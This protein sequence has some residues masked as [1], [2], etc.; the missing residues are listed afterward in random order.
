M[1]TPNMP[2]M[3]QLMKQA[4]ELQSSMQNLQKELANKI[5]TGKAGGGMVE[6]DI[7]G[8]H[9][10]KAVRISSSLVSDAE[11]RQ[12]LEDL[13]VAA[14]NDATTKVEKMSKNEISSLAT[15]LGSLPTDAGDN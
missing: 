3:K 2:D 13:I 11:D 6:I 5:V 9:Y 7:N 10:A 8:Q 12:I 4:Q 1:T 14:I 15:Q